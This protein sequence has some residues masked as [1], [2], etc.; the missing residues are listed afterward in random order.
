[1]PAPN[2]TYSIIACLIVW[3]Q[4]EPNHG[5]NVKFST[6]MSSRMKNQT[7]ASLKAFSCSLAPWWGESHQKKPLSIMTVKRNV[8]PVH[9][10]EH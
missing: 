10:L 6:M 4:A 9:C 3:N 5:P 1:M 7:P 8:V 2:V